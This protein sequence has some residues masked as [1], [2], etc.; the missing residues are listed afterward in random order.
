MAPPYAYPVA[1]IVYF[2][3]HPQLWIKTICPFLLTLV[4]GLISLIFSFVYLLPLQAHAHQRSLS[5]LACLDSVCHF[6]FA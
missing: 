5:S 3:G 6:C 2:V 4:F 1:G